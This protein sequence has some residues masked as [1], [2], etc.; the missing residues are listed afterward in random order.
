MRL[1]LPFLALS[2]CSNLLHAERMSWL[3][4]D[5]IKLGVDLDLGGAITFLA[6]KKDGANVINNFDLGRQVQLSFFSGPVPFEANGQKPAEHWRHIGWNPI[7]TG[8]DFKN[9]SRIIAHEN[10]GKLLHVAC[11][12]LQWP[13]NNVPG[14][15]TFDSWLELDGPVVKARARIT[16]TRS[17]HTQ[18]PARLQE[19]PAV[20]AN[21]SFHRVVSYQGAKPF[22]NDAV[23]PVPKPQGK[24]PWSFWPGTEGWAALVDEKDYGL[25]LITPGR[26]H[27]SGGFAGQ[28][29]P[30]DT[31]GNSTGYLA[32]Q[33]Q[34][35]LDH[36]IAYEFRYELVLGSLD[37]IR[38]RA[39]HWKPTH[40][41]V[42]RFEQDR[43]GWHYQ[44]VTDSGWPVKDHLHPRFEQDDPQLVSPQAFWQAEAA[45]YLVIEAA[46]HTMQK[47]AT[48]M[49]QPHE[50]RGF[51][52]EGLIAFPIVGDGEFHRH[53]IHLG[54]H[55]KYRG[56]MLRLRIDPVGQAESGAWMK[57]RAVKLTA[58]PEK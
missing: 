2:L 6:E 48:I 35:I 30:N 8:D 26:V 1:V 52:G 49:W 54:A 29:G 15:C 25:G 56:G 3:E 44:N 41:P 38:A 17:D 18:Y 27:F 10:D 40:P 4:N 16:N 34:E 23:T 13:L 46:F 50:G 5:R 19:L 24:H 37:E 28:P 55:P 51:S 36:N 33:G 57:L 14:E 39:A 9:A 21:A 42:W 12:P 31:H 47:Q 7:Q 11:I 45:P 43:Q 53:V 58:S 32:G 22:S 20:Y